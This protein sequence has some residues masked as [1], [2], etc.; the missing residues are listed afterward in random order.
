MLKLYTESSIKRFYTEIYNI[1]KDSDSKITE[2]WCEISEISFLN[3]LGTNELNRFL[4][5]FDYISIK[6]GNYI[7]YVVIEKIIFI[8]DCI[9]YL[10][11]DIYQLS[12]ILDYN[13]FEA[14]VKEI[15][16]RN[17]CHTT[18]NFRFSESSKLTDKSQSR[19]EI[20]VIGIYR[21]YILIIDAKQWKHKDSYS[22]ISK[23]A[24]LQLERVKALKRNPESFFKLVTSILGNNV[25]IKKYLP[26]VLIPIV[27][28]LEENSIK[29]NENHIPLVSIYE[30][31][32]FLQEFQNN[33]QYFKSIQIDKIG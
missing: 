10:K 33:L 6:S 21:K 30:F 7:S 29:F 20:D 32:S 13:G 18:C 9:K 1:L 12:E 23:A 27:V 4:E 11:Y 2:I 15:L 19:Y 24:N 25:E 26:Y 5:N 28:T 22:A 17:N 8:I 14:L 31:N 3:E 16:S